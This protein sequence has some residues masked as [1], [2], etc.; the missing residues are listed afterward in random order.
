MLEWTGIGWV[1]STAGIEVCTP[2]KL[3]VTAVSSI[4]IVCSALAAALDSAEG[5][6]VSSVSTVGETC[7]GTSQ[8]VPVKNGEQRHLLGS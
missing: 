6:V 8:L 5:M 4:I 7:N 1:D 3:L 2:G